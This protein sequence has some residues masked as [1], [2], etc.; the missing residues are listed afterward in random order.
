MVEAA[1]ARVTLAALDTILLTKTELCNDSTI[2]FNIVL[3]QIS[4]KV[5]SVTNHLKKSASGMMILFVNLKMLVKVIDSLGKNSDLHLG[6][7][8][9]ALVGGIFSHNCLFFSL[10]HVFFTSFNIIQSS[11]SRVKGEYRR[12]QRTVCPAPGNRTN[13]IIPQRLPLV[14]YFFIYIP[15]SSFFYFSGCF[16]KK[17]A[18]NPVKTAIIRTIYIFALDLYIIEW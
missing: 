8:G 5:S 1:K 16:F 7:T 13:C 4:K 12:I 18:T 11:Q 10:C 17:K 6:G 2:P 3:L 9:V 15:Q 14:K